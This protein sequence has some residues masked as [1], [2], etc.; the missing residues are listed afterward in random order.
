M[1]KGPLGLQRRKQLTEDGG[2]I[3]KPKG[4]PHK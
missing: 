1:R 4:R 3:P 2:V